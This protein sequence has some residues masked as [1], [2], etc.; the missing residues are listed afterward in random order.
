MFALGFEFYIK[1]RDGRI[2]RIPEIENIFQHVVSAQF[3]ET[4]CG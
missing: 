4:S 3:N 1:Q 2:T